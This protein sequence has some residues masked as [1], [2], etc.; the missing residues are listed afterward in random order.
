MLYLK[1]LDGQGLGNQLWNYVTLRSISSHL[2][3]KYKII[4]P[5][6]FKAKSF[7]KISY[8][9]NEVKKDTKNNISEINN[10]NIFRERLYY[11]N[12][13]KTFVSDFDKEI[14]KIKP[15]TILEG[16]FQSEKY[17]LNS[18]VNQYIQLRNSNK[19]KQKL[20]G[21]KCI[22][23]IR[24]GEYKRFKDLILPKTYWLNAI[25]NMKEIC[26]NMKFYV[27]TDD[28]D[29]AKNLLPE[30]TIL[31]G[32]IDKDFTH[33]FHSEYLIVSNSS[34]SYFPITMGKKPKK[35]IAPSKW[36]RFG[37]SE[38]RWISPANYYKDWSY[39]NEKGEIISN[40][41][42]KELINDTRHVYSKYNILTTKESITSKSLL[43]FL[44]NNFKKIIKKLLAKIF[45]L[46][47]G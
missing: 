29:Y 45:P 47:I 21:P 2:G 8:S 15:N 25:K 17:L 38:D 26:K 16:L 32:Q 27:I 31:K 28:Y 11:D 41:N 9:T 36:A 20:K 44:P 5:E 3:Y 12:S 34:F 19:F 1:F 43:S 24:G 18:D 42:I 10:T 7:L 39:Q 22:L 14:L 46:Y 4:N 13:L 30:L 35:I 23:N 6:N 40:D 33:L 37:N